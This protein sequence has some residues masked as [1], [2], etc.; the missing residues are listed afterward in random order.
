MEEK[1]ATRKINRDDVVDLSKKRRP[2]TRKKRAVSHDKSSHPQ[3]PVK[4][5]SVLKGKKKMSKPLIVF[6]V[7]FGILAIAGASYGA[8]SFFSSG[9]DTE[10]LDGAGASQEIVEETEKI[11]DNMRRTDGVLVEDVNEANKFPVAVMIENLSV[12]RPQSGLG[13]A[14]VVYETLAE[15]GITRF[16]AI[17]AGDGLEEIQPVRSSRPYYLEWVSEYDAL[18]AHAG[19]SPDALQAI[20][21]LGIHDLDALKKGQYF[22]RGP[23][24]APHNLYTSSHLLELGLRDQELLDVQPEFDPWKFKDE[25]DSGDSNSDGN[26]IDIDFSRDS[27]NASFEYSSDDNCYKRS[28]GDGVAHNEKTT[29]EQLCPKNLVVQVVPPESS[30]G[31]KGRIS[32]DVTGEGRVVVFRD[33]ETVEG[34]WKKADRVSRTRFYDESDE[35]IRLVR[36]QVWISVI[37]SDKR[38]EY[39]GSKDIK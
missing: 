7:V 24:Q 21:G 29:G 35:E 34:T 12:V 1:R 28:H 26:T 25:A 22:W 37:P 11:P 3:K 33:G 20:D 30:A 15:G 14:N 36:G 9:D 8:F 16:M 31:D 6:L 38:F 27:Y 18:Y 32:L 13:V 4:K 23:G 10:V 5:D 39:D 19:G 2:S 17:M